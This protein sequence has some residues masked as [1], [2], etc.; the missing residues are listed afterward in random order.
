MGV[1]RFGVPA[2]TLTIRLGG[3]CVLHTDGVYSKEATMANSD[4]TRFAAYGAYRL[5]AT[6]QRNMLWALGATTGLVTITVALAAVLIG[7]PTG[8]A[9]GGPGPKSWTS[10]T[11]VFIIS[12]PP[13]VLPPAPEVRPE[14]P[15]PSTNAG[16][17][18]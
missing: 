3:M 4:Q 6:Y 14:N 2:R 11:T 7:S 13:T 5:K 17:I 16:S 18:I 10:D 8:A 15:M 1:T 12:P 9:S